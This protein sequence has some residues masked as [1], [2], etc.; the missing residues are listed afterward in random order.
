M[1]KAEESPL[2]GITGISG[3]GA[4]FFLY[5]TT[6]S[7]IDATSV[8]AFLC[9]DNLFDAD[10]LM[11]EGQRQGLSPSFVLSRIRVARM[12]TLHQLAAS[13]RSRL[14]R[15]LS[16]ER[17]SGLMI[18]GIVPLF[19]EER[20]PRREAERLLDETFGSLKALLRI[21]HLPCMLSLPGSRTPSLSTTPIQRQAEAA[22][23]RILRLDLSSETL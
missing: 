11:R 10:F 9:G 18:S 15:L 6:L 13:V 20:I 14:E 12:F 7:L 19:S 22:C 2:E 4:H 1:P 16:Q 23:T 5:R 3:D 17:V 21:Y 8:V